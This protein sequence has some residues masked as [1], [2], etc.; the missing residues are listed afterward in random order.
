MYIEEYCVY[1]L[2]IQFYNIA[3]R[4][5]NTWGENMCA[6][7]AVIYR[8]LFNFHYYDCYHDY[9][10]YYYNNH[11]HTDIINVN[12]FDQ[13]MILIIKYVLLMSSL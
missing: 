7:I 10:H 6:I 8:S 12:K 11:D 4:E 13:I 1:I 5:Q 9:F 3:I 2:V